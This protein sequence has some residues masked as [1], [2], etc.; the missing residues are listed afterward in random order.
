[1]RSRLWHP[2]SD[3]VLG[4]VLALSIAVP[5][6]IASQ[7]AQRFQI[8]VTSGGAP[9]ANATVCVGVPGDLNQYFQGRTDAQGRIAF[10]SIPE[11]PFV[12]T[13]H[14]GTR[15]VQ[16]TIA[17]ARPGGLPLAIVNL[18]VPAA[19]GPVCPTT[20]AG[21]A[22]LIGTRLREIP[23]PQPVERPSSIVLNLNT[24][25]CFG[26][27]GMQCGQPQANLPVSIALCASGRCQINGGSWEH[28]ECC[29]AH[30]QGMACQK[31]PLDALTGHSGHCVAAWD[32]AV[33]LFTK[34]LMW[35]REV[36]FNRPNRTGIVEFNLYCAPKGA[37]VPPG[38][39]NKCCSRRTRALTP[40]EAAA[41]AASGET[42]LACQ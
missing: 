13:A 8:N 14:V 39:A 19:G 30:P 15:G 11:A 21:S 10:D 1:M 18:T 5:A 17:S 31:G 6:A 9:L 4:V 7:L 16:Q 41:S 36:D 25:F 33:R 12:V 32:K 27:L 23:P 29:A 2:R 38:D 24:Q 3:A 42:L 34:G 28:D 20:A 35:S 40:T 37:L 22:R 26:A